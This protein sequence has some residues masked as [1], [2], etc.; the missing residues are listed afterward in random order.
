[1]RFDS[2][3]ESGY[4]YTEQLYQDSLQFVYNHGLFDLSYIQRH[5]PVILEQMPLI[6]DE[7]P[8]VLPS[9]FGMAIWVTSPFLLYAFF[10]NI[11]EYRA[12]WIPAAIALGISAVILLSRGLA[13]LWEGDWAT[14]EIPWGIHLLPFWVLS[15]GAA[16]AGVLVP[17]AKGEPWD[18]LVVA[19]WAAIIPTALLIFTFA[20]TGWAQFGYRYAL[21]FTP[22]LWLLAIRTIGNDMRWHHVTLIAVAIAVNAMGVLW[23][24]QFEPAQ[25]NGWSWITF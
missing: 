10:A 1:M 21:D 13:R 17:R 18:R 22:F 9:W 20:A 15:F 23:V 12:L 16:A 24:Y 19:C 14:S 3:F 2:P 7:G 25:T 5:P 4:G 11:K 6:K 8:Y